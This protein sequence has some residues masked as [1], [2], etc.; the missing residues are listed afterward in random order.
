MKA[1]P[2]M[3]NICNRGI[4]VNPTCPI[5]NGEPESIEHVII[6]R[7]A[8]KRVWSKWNDNLICLNES[9]REIM[10]LALYLLEK[11]TQGDME[12]FFGVV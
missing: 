5:C 9:N 11:G 7:E 2:S 4:Q 8:T 6:Q 3:L 10:D 1:I 12:I